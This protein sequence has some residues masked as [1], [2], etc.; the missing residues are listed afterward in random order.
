MELLEYKPRLNVRQQL[1][2]KYRLQGLSQYRAARAA[3]YS[4]STAWNAHVSIEKRCNFTEIMAKEGLDDQSLLQTIK[5]GIAVRS[6]ISGNPTLVTKAFVEIALKVSGRLKEKDI[7]IK[8]DTKINVFPQRTV[9]F[10]G[11]DDLD[12]ANI[13]DIYATKGE[14]DSRLKL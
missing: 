3:G 11:I 8:N 12:Q 9:V 7:N 13:Q 4:H 1:Y 5:E 14:E 2:K 6:Q 10:T